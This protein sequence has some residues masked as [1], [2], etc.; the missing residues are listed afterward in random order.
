MIRVVG[1]D[2][3]RVVYNLSASDT[4][5]RSPSLFHYFL[6]LHKQKEKAMFLRHDGIVQH[7]SGCKPYKGNAY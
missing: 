2:S 5:T 1:A 7:V 3:C 4:I 6:Q